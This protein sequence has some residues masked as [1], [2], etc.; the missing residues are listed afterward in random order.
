MVMVM[1]TFE[2]YLRIY[3]YL[4][5]LLAMNELVRF[6]NFVTNNRTL[7]AYFCNELEEEL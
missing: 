2:I 3:N 1:V 7:I 5:R 6:V 4:Y